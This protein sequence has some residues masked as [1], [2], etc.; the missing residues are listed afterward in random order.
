MKTTLTPIILLFFCVS[1]YSQIRVSDIERVVK[2]DEVLRWLTQVEGQE[3]L[4][5]ENAEETKITKVTNTGVELLYTPKFRPRDAAKYYISD[6]CQSSQPL[7]FKEK[8]L[9][10]FYSN[11][12]YLTDITTGILFKNFQLS[13]DTLS[14]GVNDYAVFGDSLLVTVRN[15][16]NVTSY[17]LINVSTGRLTSLPFTWNEKIYRIRHMMYKFKGNDLVGYNVLNGNETT[18][19]SAAA[20]YD[21]I[22]FFYSDC[23]GHL[24]F[25]HN[26]GSYTHIGSD[27]QLLDISCP[28]PS[29]IKNMY[30]RD[31]IL[32]MVV[33]TNNQSLTKA[34]NLNS[35]DEIWNIKQEL[36]WYDIPDLG[37]GLFMLSIPGDYFNNGTHYVLDVKNR[38]LVQLT[39][40][41]NPDV[42]VQNITAI[43]DSVLYVV[44]VDDIELFGYVYALNA[45]DLKKKSMDRI[46]FYTGKTEGQ[47]LIRDFTGTTLNVITSAFEGDVDLWKLEFKQKKANYLTSLLQER[48][49]GLQYVYNI[50]VQDNAL[51][52]SIPGGIYLTKGNETKKLFDCEFSSGLAVYNGHLF[53]LVQKKDRKI[54]FIKIN[55]QSLDTKY[56]LLPGVS[57]ID[58]YNKVTGHVILN[59]QGPDEMNNVFLNLKTEKYESIKI[60]GVKTDMYNEKVS[61]DM[62]LFSDYEGSTRKTYLWNTKTGEIIKLLS[63]LDNYFITYP[64]EEGNFFISIDLDGKQYL[65][66]LNADGNL[67]HL[68]EIP[69]K[70]EYYY[71]RLIGM[72][73]PVKTFAVPGNDEVIFFSEKEG[74]TIKNVLPF[75]GTLYYQSFFWKEVNETVLVETTDESGQYIQWVWTYGQPPAKINLPF[76]GYRLSEAII[77]GDEVI[78]WYFKDNYSAMKVVHYSITSASIVHTMEVN[79]TIQN[80]PL[81]SNQFAKI[82]DDLFVI[83]YNDG[84]SGREPWLYNKANHTFKRLK[85]LYSGHIGSNP[86]NFISVAGDCYFTAIDNDKSRQWF[87]VNTVLAGLENEGNGEIQKLTVSPN[88]ASSNISFDEYIQSADIYDTRARSLHVFG[89]LLPGEIKDISFLPAGMYLIH[90]RLANKTEKVLKLVKM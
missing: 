54:G 17:L 49:T 50:R 73:G 90:V 74:N 79:K 20:P 71:N 41:Y 67:Q 62:V 42:F 9:V 5:E 85:D 39:G 30:I 68:D 28:L 12:V 76:A 81:Y 55:L 13:T 25:G 31:S 53:A 47:V 61:G 48:N 63:P 38:S 15:Q 88:P 44:S 77:D 43:K 57:L 8:Y 26:N 86:N 29:A 10:E 33:T 7:K 56:T 6:K 66:K 22:R 70:P 14:F 82:Q 64:D 65:K 16:T 72:D 2:P 21:F 46:V 37:S 34:I 51:F 36:I 78:I 3:Y 59:R 45:I 58:P 11:V 4:I 69:D 23:E 60:N 18:I 84:E 32:L 27:Q 89:P 87:K 52:T 19:A 75:N 40:D 24:V 83:A 80:Y 1:I 35:C